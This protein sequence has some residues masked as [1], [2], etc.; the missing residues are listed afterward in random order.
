[1]SPVHKHWTN[2]KAHIQH[3]GDVENKP[4]GYQGS[5]EIGT[6]IFTLLYVRQMTNKNSLNSIGNSTQCSAMAYTGKEP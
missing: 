5:W 2:K 3:V 6:D 4:N 1:M